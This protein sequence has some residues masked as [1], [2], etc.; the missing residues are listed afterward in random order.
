MAIFGPTWVLPHLWTNAVHWSFFWL[1]FRVVGND[2]EDWSKDLFLRNG[3]LVIHL[4]AVQ[5]G[6]CEDLR[7][8][9]Q[10]NDDF[11]HEA[12]GGSFQHHRSERQ[13]LPLGA[14]AKPH[15]FWTLLCE[16]VL[17]LLQFFELW[18]SLLS[19]SQL[20]LKQS[21]FFNSFDSL[22]LPTS[23]Q[24]FSTLPTSSQLVSTTLTSAHLFSTLRSSSQLFSPLAT[25]SQLFPPLLTSAQLISP[26]S[27]LISTLPTSSSQLLSTLPNSSH[28]F[29]QR[30]FTHRSFY[31]FLI[32]FLH[33][34]AFAQRSFG[35]EP[36][37]TQRSFYT[38]QA[39]IESKLLRRE[40]F[41]HRSA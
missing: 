6:A 10:W 9:V 14:G 27:Q 39:F 18:P 36:A 24:L 35:T 25:S 40:A 7:S 21:L 29:S 11:P 16:F 8:D 34:E 2:G 19:S 12:G 31:T 33:T 3:H 32:H 37:F 20:F 17:I 23:A 15:I 28:L 5:R 13:G 22:S 41:T 38:E 26:L 30:C 4:V 1:L